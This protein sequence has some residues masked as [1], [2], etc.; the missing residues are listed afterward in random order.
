MSSTA[1]GA[2]S[3][4]GALRMNPADQRSKVCVNMRLDL[5]VTTLALTHLPPPHWYWCHIPPSQLSGLDAQELL[6]TRVLKISG[7]DQPIKYASIFDRDDNL[8]VASN[9]KS[10]EVRVQYNP[11]SFVSD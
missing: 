9:A 2:A 3:D 1:H 5:C 4:M 7:A 6:E 10:F 8:R 11:F